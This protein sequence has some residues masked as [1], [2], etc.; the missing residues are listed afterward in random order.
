MSKLRSFLRRSEERLRGKDVLP[1]PFHYSKS[2]FI[3]I[4]KAG[5]SSLSMAIYGCQ[6][7][8]AML[9]DYY[10]SLGDKMA[11]YRTFTVCRDPLHRAFSAFSYLQ[12]GGSTSYDRDV[13]E[14]YC[15][16]GLSFDDFVADFL[17]KLIS[18]RVIHFIP[19]FEFVERYR[20]GVIGVDKVFKYEDI[21]SNIDPLS[22]FLSCDVSVDS[23]N[24]GQGGGARLF[25][26]DVRAKVMDIYDKDYW[27][28]G[29][30]I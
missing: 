26:D 15:L 14:R 10:F 16:A 7:G 17:P 12:N 8:H 25:G 1:G 19:Q 28:F 3:H 23:L 24:K 11:E 9:K 27:L 2:I 21:F 18:D 5:G 20:G 29:Y 6:V 13:K 30:N 22:E 4:P